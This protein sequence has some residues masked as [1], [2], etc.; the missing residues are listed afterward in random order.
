MRYVIYARKSTEEDDR[1]VLSIESQLEELRLYSAKEKF[2]I[3]SGAASPRSA[4][5]APDAPRRRR[6][7]GW[8]ALIQVF[9]TKVYIMH[10][11]LYSVW[12]ANK[13][14]RF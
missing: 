9:C 6:R 13:R 10:V 5:F 12:R 7:R 14:G 4:F 11:V 2:D 3:V 8:F 1:Q